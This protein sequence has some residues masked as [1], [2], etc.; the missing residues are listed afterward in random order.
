MNGS[1]RD[2]TSDV[3]T[4]GDEISSLREVGTP[5]KQT[6]SSDVRGTPTKQTEGSEVPGTPIKQTSSDVPRTP[7]VQTESSDRMTSG[8]VNA[9]PPLRRSGRQRRA[10]VHFGDYV[11]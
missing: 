4:D 1:S 10:P 5:T 2:R 8:V 11:L 6:K 7:T 3:T 9:G